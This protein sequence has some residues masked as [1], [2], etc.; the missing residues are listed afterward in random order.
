MKSYVKILYLIIIFFISPFSYVYPQSQ[1]QSVESFKTFQGLPTK[2]ATSVFKDSRGFMWFGAE[3]GLYRWDGYDYK[4]F[5]YDPKDSTS[6]SGNMISRILFEDDE[7]NI[8]IGTT[9]SGL[10]IYNPNTETFTHYQRSQ[11]YVF[12]FNFNQIRWGL[13]DK[14]GDIWLATQYTS[15]IINFDK[16]TGAF[17][18]YR[19]NMDTIDSNANRITIISDDG[20]G[21]LLVGTYQGLYFFKKE[22]KTFSN[23]GSIVKTTEELNNISVSS[24]LEDQEGIFWIGSSAGL[25]KYN[26]KENKVDHFKNDENDPVSSHSDFIVEIIDNPTDNG[27][28][29]WIVTTTGIKKF[30]KS[31]E[32]ITC[33]NDDPDDPKSKSF[34]AMYDLLLEDNGMLWVATGFGAI[35]YNLNTNPFTAYQLGPFGHEPY[36]YEATAFQEDGQGSFWVGTGYSG[37]LKY[38]QQMNLVKRY[39][40][41]FNNP[42]SLSYYFVFSLY[43]D[44]RGIL[45]VGTAASLDVLDQKN[46][47]FLHCSLPADIDYSY[48]RIND[49]HEDDSGVLWIASRGGIYYQEKKELLD[50]S[51][52]QVPYFADKMVDIRCVA[53]DT[54]GNIWF[55]SNGSGL[56]LLSPEDRKTMSIKNFRHNPDDLLSICDDVIWSIYIDKNEHLWLGTSNGLNRIDPKNNQYYHYNK[57]NG[58]EANFIYFI[59]EDNNGNL[60]LSTER[61]IMRFNPLSD[62]E[63]R[64]KLLELADGIPFE[65]NYQFRIYKGNDG[66]IYVGGQ[67]FSGNGFYCFHPDSLKDNDHIP[68]IVLTEFLVNN[69]TIK[70]DSS[71]TNMKYMELSHNQNFFSIKFAALDFVNPTKNNYAYKL[72]GF[73]EDWVFCDTRRMANYTNVPPGDY[74]FRVKGSNNDGLWNEQG[75]TLKITIFPPPWRTWWAYS[76]YALF[77]IGL[78]YAWRR[79]DLKRQRLKQQLEVEHVQT[80]KLEELD[81]MKSRFFANISHEFRTPLTLILGPL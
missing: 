21:N 50:I 65:N 69:K 31:T 54:L 29:L 23:F 62:T 66:K 37:L 39:D 42:E 1:E 71:I 28:S 67:R 27:K 15:G 36:L 22:T 12:D 49:I 60:W 81:R 7:G 30:D 55:A 10:N 44:S 41:D 19:P 4:I 6:I 63:G 35:R 11:D 20:T 5:H 2:I 72:E 80:E 78:L 52:Q 46:D 47:R 40:C 56:Y 9:A 75:A 59:E 57:E 45:W 51:F 76:L 43:E 26:T 64:S 8:W 61:G 16:T 38:D 13:Q 17:I 14:D 58:L 18:T 68:P 3:N 34:K 70:S 48:F 77:L 33:F 74:I 32:I 73:D 25:L 53:E 24:I 79:Y